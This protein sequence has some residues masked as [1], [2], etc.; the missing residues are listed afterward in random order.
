VISSGPKGFAS[1]QALKK[2]AVHICPS[3]LRSETTSP[4]WKTRVWVL[5]GWLFSVWAVSHL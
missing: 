2:D 1:E 5:F 4:F 3:H